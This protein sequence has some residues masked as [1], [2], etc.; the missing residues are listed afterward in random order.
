MRGI[1]RSSAALAALLVLGACGAPSTPGDQTNS[2]ATPAV[3][4]NLVALDAAATAWAS[5]GTLAK[6]KAGAE[7]ARNLVTG[8]D[9]MGYGDLDGTATPVAR[10]TRGCC[11]ARRGSPAWSPR[12]SPRASSAT[13]LAGA[14]LIRALAGQ[15]CAIASKGGAR[16]TT[17]S[18]R[19][20]AT[21]SASSVGPA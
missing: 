1:A 10:A 18:Q 20:P 7:T 6:A 5:T 14:G 9:V 4:A 3:K 19:W 13:F 17:L 16:A 21:P 15:T 2:S 12:P 11:Q 8:P